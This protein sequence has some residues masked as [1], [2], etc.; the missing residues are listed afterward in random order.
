MAR[1]LVEELIFDMMESSSHPRLSRPA[2]GRAVTRQMDRNENAVG[3]KGR[4]KSMHLSSTVNGVEYCDQEKYYT[5]S[6]ASINRLKHRQVHR[7]STTSDLQQK[8][9]D[10]RS[11]NGVVLNMKQKLTDNIEHYSNLFQEIT[12]PILF[13]RSGRNQRS[14]SSSRSRN[15]SRSSGG[16]QQ[17]TSQQAKIISERT[18]EDYPAIENIEL[19]QFDGFVFGSERESGKGHNFK[20]L[21]LSAPTWCDRC[22]EFI[23][24]VYKQCL[25]CQ[26]EFEHDIIM[27]S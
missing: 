21:Q 27:I 3:Q 22:G 17:G 11:K 6:N 18:E 25:R 26:S 10:D 4:P 14:R 9:P 23:W 19:Y 15:E 5:A 16:S 24:G 1:E 12:F 2:P 20:P 8:E 7:S 13:R